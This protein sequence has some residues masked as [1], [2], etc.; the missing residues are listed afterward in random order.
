MAG[1]EGCLVK[2]TLVEN[3]K[4]PYYMKLIFGEEINIV[5]KFSEIDVKI[6]REMEK[7]HYPKKKIYSSRKITKS[8]RSPN[9]KK[10]LLLA[11]QAVAS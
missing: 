3:L 8:L 9:F 1:K 5:E 11:F 10:Q 6:I 2:S 4:N 7:N